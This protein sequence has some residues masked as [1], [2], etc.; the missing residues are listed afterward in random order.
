VP[1]ELAQYPE[2]M[3]DAD[4]VRRA[5][6]GDRDAWASIYDRYA[7]RLHDYAWTIVRNREDA[8]DA[9]QDTF[10]AAASKIGQLRDPSALRSWLYA[11]CRNQA[12]GRTRARAR[13]V[14]TEQVPELMSP[15]PEQRDL[16]IEEMRTLVWDAAGGLAP[17][18][19]A[20]LDLHL[21]Q[22]LESAELG[23]ALEVTAHNATV[24]LS[25]VRD[26]PVG[27]APSS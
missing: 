13:E 11:I 6:T 19:R 24:M 18:D 4:L 15:A 9:L 27:R 8:E 17:R 25:R 14:P 7:D 5:A 12:L 23:A 22:G 20:V 26:R 2:P 21:R 10:V 1:D 16:D 3:D